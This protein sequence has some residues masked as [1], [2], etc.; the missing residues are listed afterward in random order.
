MFKL[1]RHARGSADRARK[2]TPAEGA[3]GAIRCR[4]FSITFDER[5][6]KSQKRL[7]PGLA[8]L[9]PGAMLE[10]RSADTGTAQKKDELVAAPK[11]TAVLFA[12]RSI[13][14]YRIYRSMEY[15][16]YRPNAFLQP[17]ARRLS[18]PE[19]RCHSRA[20]IEVFMQKSISAQSRPERG[21]STKAAVRRAHD[22]GPDWGV[23]GPLGVTHQ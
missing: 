5:C 19:P 12:A 16:V 8:D 6:H 13:I 21:G 1:I 20:Q 2:R 18:Q 3:P 11:L 23:T 10:R 4:Q 22:I 15:Q 7:E 9:R 17:S 14:D